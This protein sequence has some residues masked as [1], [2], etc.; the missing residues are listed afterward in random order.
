MNRQYAGKDIRRRL[1]AALLSLLM[2]LQTVSVFAEDIAVPETN[3]TEITETIAEMVQEPAEEIAATEGTAAPS[4]TEPAEETTE[5]A[6]EESP[7][8]TSM[9]APTAEEPD[10]ISET[11]EIPD[12][13]EEIS[14]GEF[15]PLPAENGITAES[16]DT[17][18]EIPEAPEATPVID[19][20]ESITMLQAGF[21]PAPVYFEGTLVH[22]GQDYTVTAVIGKDAMFPADVAMRVE[23]I[24]PGTEL[25]EFYIQMME[26]TMEADEEMGEFARF[27]DIAFIAEVNGET[28][29][30]EPQADIDV[31]ITFQEA[32]AVTEETDVQ[33]VHIEDDIPQILDASTDSLEAAIHDEEAIDTVSF[34]SDSFSVYGVYQKVKKILK[35]ITANGET[36]TIDVT[37]TSDSGIPDDADLSAREITP[38][39][40]EYEE[41]RAQAVLALD[42]GNVGSA[43]FF[44]IEISKDGEKIEPAGPVNVTI[45]L[46][47]MPEGAET[48]AVVHFGEESTEIIEEVEISDTDVQF[49]ADSFSVYGVITD[50]TNEAN[51]LN[52]K[53]ATISRNGEYLTG[54]TLDVPPRMIGK[55]TN[56]NEAAQ[57]YFVSTGEDGKYYVYTIDPD[58]QSKLYINFRYR[59]GQSREA[60]CYLSVDPQE[61]SVEQFGNDY[62]ISWRHPAGTSFALDHWAGGSGD[63][64]GGYAVSSGGGISDNHRMSLN[65][66]T[67]TE[68]PQQRYVVIIKHEGQYYT[69]Q[70]DGSLLP[71]EY[72][73]ETNLVEMESPLM[74]TYSGVYW[75][76]D[77]ARNLKITEEALRFDENQLPVEFSYRYINPNADSGIT[78]ETVMQNGNN[79]YAISEAQNSALQYE[80]NKL[81]GNG[82][83]NYIGVTEENGK[84]KITGNNDLSSAAEV[85]M[86]VPMLPSSAYGTTNAVNHI[87]ISVSGSANLSLALAYGTYYDQ[88]GRRIV[89]DRDNPYTYEVTNYPITIQQ[90]DMIH[91]EI[92]AYK[93]NDDGSTTPLDDMF[94][95]TGYS[96]NGQ[97][98]GSTESDQVRI[99]GFFKVSYTN[100]PGQNGNDISRQAR[101]ATPVY[102]T[103]T[104]PKTVTVPL[105]YNGLTLYSEDPR[106][107][108]N[109]QPVEVSTTVMLSASISYWDYQNNKCPA[110]INGAGGNWYAGDIPD[111]YADSG[112]HTA[113]GMDFKLNYINNSGTIAVEVTKYIVDQKGNPIQ[114]ASE[115]KYSFDIYYTKDKDA[116]YIQNYHGTVDP[117]VLDTLDLDSYTKLHNKSI[118]VGSNGTGTL[119][120]YDV[121]SLVADGGY[122]MI[123]IK[124]NP[125]SIDQTIVDQNGETWEYTGKTRIVTE[126]VRRLQTRDDHEVTGLTGFP[127]VIGRF[128]YLDILGFSLYRT[129]AFLDFYVYNEY[130]NNK[131]EIQITKY[132]VD[133]EGNVINPMTPVENKFHLYGYNGDPDSVIGINADPSQNPGSYDTSFATE[134]NLVDTVPVTVDTSGWGYTYKTTATGRMYTIREDKDSVPRQIVD[135]EGNIWRYT[136]TEIQT[137]YVWRGDGDQGKRHYSIPFTLENGD[138]TAVPEVLGAYTGTDGKEWYNEYLDF[139]VYNKYTKTENK[140]DSTNMNLQLNKLWSKDGTI[141]PIESGSV[142]FRLHQIKTTTTTSSGGSGQYTIILRSSRNGQILDRRRGNIGD[143]FTYSFRAGAQAGSNLCVDRLYDYG[144][145]AVYYPYVQADNDGYGSFSYTVVSDDIYNDTVELYFQNRIRL[146]RL[147]GVQGGSSSGGGSTTVTTEMDPVGSGFPKDIQ[148]TAGKGWTWTGTDLLA[149]VERN[150][151]IVDYS[152][153]VEEIGRTGTAITYPIVTYENDLG[154]NQQHAVSLETSHTVNVTNTYD[155]SIPENEEITVKKTWKDQAGNPLVNHP[156]E[157]TVHIYRMKIPGTS[158]SGLVFNSVGGPYEVIGQPTSWGDNGNQIRTD[159]VFYYNGNYYYV[160]EGQFIFNRAQLQ[161]WIGQLDQGE[162]DGDHTTRLT[163]NIWTIEEVKHKAANN[164]EIQRGDICIYEGDY[165]VFRHTSGPFGTT[166]HTYGPDVDGNWSKIG[167]ANIYSGITID[168]MPNDQY[169]TENEIRTQTIPQLRDYIVQQL[170][171]SGTGIVWPE[172]ERVLERIDPDPGITISNVDKWSMK[173]TAA[174]GYLYFVF[175]DP[176]PGYTTTYG[177]E[178]YGVYDQDQSIEIVNKKTPT[179][180]S[181]TKVWR[182]NGEN[183]NWQRQITV[184][185]YAY[186]NAGQPNEKGTYTLSPDTDGHEGWTVTENAGGVTFTIGGLEAFDDNGNALTY[187]VKEVAIDGFSTTYADA[188]GQEINGGDRALNGQQIINTQKVDI[189]VIKYKSGTTQTMPDAYFQLYKKDNNG[190]YQQELEEPASTGNDGTLL[191]SALADGEYRIVETKAPAGYMPLAK[192]IEFKIQHGAVQFSGYAG[193][194]GLV[195]YTGATANAVDTFVVY[196]KPGVALPS[197]GGSGTA[198]Y[199]AAGLAMMIL[200]GIVLFKRKR[201]AHK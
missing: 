73:P 80:N 191:F 68:Q 71:C 59:G 124:E 141:E 76:G 109:A 53:I 57:Y 131:A 15:E 27:F 197:T 201:E 16:A 48:V 81:H 163:G 162:M 79:H 41:L 23:E 52:G 8:D 89:V 172:E 67:G 139:F 104:V 193:E 110:C 74:W 34:S 60:D 26:E 144:W 5:P 107:N 32:I 40:P 128:S 42:A 130:T 188:A 196:N 72:H 149:H 105:R 10:L 4:E 91:S 33:A 69:V 136:G 145:N 9:E 45:A 177:Y 58:T 14:T 118:I 49:Q 181:F 75:P 160:R 1:L 94:Y 13:N 44:D 153:Y 29:E 148:L 64:F 168:L 20:S 179:E 166:G 180:F 92:T 38:E 106:N 198:A 190:V 146:F 11:T 61:L 88:F 54:T 195:E 115:P 122:A 77:T 156:D 30:I 99:D 46:D 43:H 176:I 121:A 192:P 6:S 129:N 157:I 63:G 185:L 93:K 175:E 120:D 56:A 36:F 152:Y 7:E 147:T 134:A 90:E 170:A 85:Y 174:P 154:K 18:E 86:A 183:I 150:N 50:P 151:T 83:S 194:E 84:L 112:T 12:G 155:S 28:A 178:E 37:F 182:K 78:V 143:T 119:Y 161:G 169:L 55:T 95:V 21:V 108:P 102:Y 140:I 100:V 116:N 184:T 133:E 2:L 171:E 142:T 167:K 62:R 125:E 158:S 22:E 113:S 31:Q 51:N 159:V 126:Y 66:V 132:L 135:T 187:Y 138:Y 87:D 96:N 65:F 117:S 186:T 114:V 111:G 173:F 3:P 39:D 19:M 17:P 70:S 189:Q 98:D 47:E 82:N 25:Y 101:L 103:V 165:W 24:L 123:Y 199:T 35:V 200:A 97:N 127:E 164:V 137:E